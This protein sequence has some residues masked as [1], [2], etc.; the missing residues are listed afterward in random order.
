MHAKA[1]EAG[2][3]EVVFDLEDAVA[4]GSKAVAR[5]QVARTLA[6]PAWA[7]RRVAVRVNRSGSAAQ[8]E[9]LSM[10]GSL[11]L[12]GLTIVVPKVE[13]P[14][15]L[16]AAARVA[17][18]QALIETPQGL[19]AASAIASQDAVETLILGYAD[20]AAA[21]GRRGAE[22]DLDRWLVAQ[23]ALLAGARIGA[24]QAIDGPFF[25]LG[26]ERGV[27]NAARAARELGFDGKWAIHP[28]QIEAI[29]AAFSPSPRERRW[30]AAVRTAVE[31][32]GLQGGAAATVDGAM[33]DEAMLRQAERV[34]AL[35]CE[36]EPDT[37]APP[38]HRVAAPYYDDLDRGDAFTAPGLTLTE[39]HAALHQSIVGDRLR[40]SLD[41]TLY[42]AV[43]GTPGLLAHPML[44]CDVAIGQSTA[45]SARVLGNLFYRGLGARPVPVGT[46][47]RTTTRVVGRR[48]ASRGRGIV[49]LHVRTVD[50]S[51]EPILDFWR[52]PL[53]PSRSDGGGD[54]ADD[55]T[56]VG[57]PV[58]ATTLVPYGWRLDP[59]RAEP[60]GALFTDVRAGDTYGV[61]AAETVTA[62]TELAR[63]SLN[64]AHTHTDASAGAHGDRLVYGGHVIGIA[65]AHV[66]RALPDLATILAW[67][68]CDH[69]GPSFEGDRLRSR[70][71]ITD[72][73]PLADGG[74][75]HLRVRSAA[76]SEAGPARD[77][78][79]WRLVA[80]LP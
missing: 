44:V 36:A 32:A 14:A 71:E 70:I 54:D 80:L 61:E 3:D 69:L 66:T 1:L 12:E 45:P 21:L 76:T 8:D 58:D 74:L 20:L 11:G 37:T 60:L 68:S 6:S 73:H 27:S 16:E 67:E 72:V 47:L 38:T 43:S 17:P 2:A 65:A 26:D 35:P 48:D 50:G 9:D 7:R 57:K 15:D 78:L 39:G 52:A 23:E 30:A 41:A 56:L 24:A 51:G 49:A 59:L 13:S 53:L 18:V 33:V 29:N 25:G 75:V 10:C 64:L 19:A 34:L 5:E 28:A 31:D 46:T 55:L 63:L 40:L 79:D 22:H 62:A 77:V 4:A 42:E